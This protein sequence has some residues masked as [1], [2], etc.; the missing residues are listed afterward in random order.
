MKLEQLH[1]IHKSKDFKKR[2]YNKNKKKKML[3]PKWK[4][5]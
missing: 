3:K 2:D 1:L 4:Q 5:K